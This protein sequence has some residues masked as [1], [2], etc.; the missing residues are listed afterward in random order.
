MTRK[1][2]ALD[3]LLLVAVALLGVKVRREWLA[4]RA[5]EQAFMQHRVAPKPAQPLVALVQPPPSTAT[6]YAQVAEKNLFSKDRNSNVILDPP[7]P[8][9]VKP[10]PPFPTA[11]GVM[12]WDGVP[13]TVVLSDRPGGSQ[14]GYHPGDTI[15]EWKIIS[16]DNQYLVLSWEGKEFKKRL[17]ELLDKTTLTVAEATAPQAGG[18]AAANVMSTSSPTVQSL[19]TSTPQSPGADMGTARACQAGDTSPPGSVVGGLK[20]VVSQSPFGGS[21]CRWEPVK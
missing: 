9:V 20:K 17:D 12:L 18:N 4:A 13:P 19:S 1:L 11:R 14:K 2:L 10:V 15:G 3:L 8:I 6:L 5:R 16:V 21:T 7:P